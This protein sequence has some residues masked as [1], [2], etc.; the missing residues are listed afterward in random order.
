MLALTW[1]GKE[2]GVNYD[3]QG[4]LKSSMKFSPCTISWERVMHYNAA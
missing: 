4:P 3:D 2:A 1:I